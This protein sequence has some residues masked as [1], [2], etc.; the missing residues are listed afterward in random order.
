MIKKIFITLLL[1]IF[2]GSNFAYSFE[3]SELNLEFFE[4]FQDANLNYYILEALNNNHD[5]KI[6]SAKSVEFKEQARISLGREL[7]SLS[8]GANYLGLK[9]P[10]VQGL[11]IDNNI[12]ILPF[13]ARYEIDLL[14][15]NRDK[16]KSAQ[17]QHL[18]Q[19]ESEKAAYITLLADVASV[20]INAIYNKELIEKQNEKITNQLQILDFDK[21]KFKYGVINETQLNESEKTFKNLLIE[22]DNLLKHQEVTLTQLALLCAKSPDEIKDFK[23]GDFKKFEYNGEI[24]S[25]ISSDVIFSRPDVMSVEAKL[26]SAG[27]DIKVARKEFLPTFNLL[28]ILTFNTFTSG[29]FFSWEALLA[30]LLAG[31]TQDIFK[32]GTKVANLKIKKAKY[33]QLFEQYKQTDINALKEVN[34]ALCLIKYDNEIEK[35]TLLKLDFEKENF[36]NS[37]NSLNQGAIALPE[38]LRANVSY[39]NIQNEASKTKTNRIINYITLYKAV[40][41]SL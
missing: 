7:P 31:A 37:K 20:Y 39:I 8:V 40:G 23:L 38:H 12:F 36:N 17:K 5:L 35:N 25:E 4:K 1:I 14:A 16:T 11:D 29:N 13:I 18:A 22:L 24:P 6:A 21:K 34:N 32:G 26:E 2:C 33:E 10:E 9:T 19:Q 30:S 3:K 41:G 28:G 15:K 27:I